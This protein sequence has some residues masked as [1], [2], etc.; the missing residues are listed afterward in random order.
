MRS[1]T[2]TGATATPFAFVRTVSVRGPLLPKRPLA[3]CVGAANVTGTPGT[4]LPC[5]S[6]TVTASGI[7]KRE[8][9]G[10]DSVAA[11]PAATEWGCAGRLRSAKLASASAPV[12][13]AVAVNGPAVAFAAKRGETAIP[14]AFVV[15]VACAAPPGKLA[16][17]AAAPPP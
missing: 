2:N 9:A 4:G 16:P 10:V 11:T 1:A 7:G 3:P 14:E 15:A 17:A 6:S 12:A 13:E 8:P 5:T